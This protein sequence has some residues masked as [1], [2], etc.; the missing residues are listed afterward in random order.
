[1]MYV[2]GHSFEFEKNDNWNVI[3][4]FCSMISN[5]DDIWY[6]TNI[7]IVDYLESFERLQFAADRSFVYNPNV[8]SCWITINDSK[9]VELKGGETT[10]LSEE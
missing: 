9:I 7:E 6:A 1:M 3:E 10:F 2:W 5:Q 8:A 4:E